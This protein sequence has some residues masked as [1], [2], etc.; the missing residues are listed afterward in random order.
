MALGKIKLC[1]IVA[2]NQPKKANVESLMTSYYQMTQKKGLFNGKERTYKPEDDDDE[3]FPDES[4]KVQVKALDVLDE[5]KLPW[6]EM[7]D[8]VLTN[9]YGNSLA[10]ADV[11]ID[12]AIVLK[13]VPIQTL[14]WMCKQLDHWTAILKELPTLPLSNNW[15][16]DT[17]N[18]LWKSELV[19]THKTKKVQEG[20]IIAPATDKH[21][22]Q[23]QLITVDKTVGYWS[24][25]EITSAIPSTKVE[26][27]LRRVEKF[28]EGVLKAK[29]EANTLVIDQQ[30]G[31]Q[32]IL[33]F[34]FG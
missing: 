1:Q 26:E 23:A 20:I 18:N 15:T 12:G 2:L 14:L 33:D 13:Q 21:A 22:A 7:F 4:V 17:S 5:Y 10:K 34:I 24:T 30:E 19:K 29:E 32:A 25:I 6:K 11:V 8:V 28:K 16:L 27:L 3:K 31:G 9:D